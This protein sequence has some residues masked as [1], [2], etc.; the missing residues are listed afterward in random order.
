VVTPAAEVCCSPATEN[1]RFAKVYD[2]FF[3]KPAGLWF[4]LPSFLKKEV[5]PGPERSNRSPMF[6]LGVILI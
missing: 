2:V 1:A 4:N 3:A 6:N 5:G